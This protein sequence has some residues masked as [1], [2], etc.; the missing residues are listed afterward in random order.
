VRIKGKFEYGD[1][2]GHGGGFDKQIV[3]SEVELVLWS[4]PAE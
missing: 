4:P 2:Y 3:P 1:N